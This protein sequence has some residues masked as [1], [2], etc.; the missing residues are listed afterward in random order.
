[1][2]MR[3]WGVCVM[4]N[5]DGT[6]GESRLTRMVTWLTRGEVPVDGFI[7]ADENLAPNIAPSK[8]DMSE[9]LREAEDAGL[10]PRSPVRWGNFR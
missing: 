8:D 1:M 6:A 7:L 10:I 2:K 3:G 5:G 4:P 9:C